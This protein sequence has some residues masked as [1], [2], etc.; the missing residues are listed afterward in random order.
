ML[1]D[2]LSVT[3]NSVAKS[4]PR[5]GLS[6]SR[7]RYMTVDKEFRVEITRAP[8]QRDGIVRVSIELSRQIPDPTP[9]NV[10][11]D[12]REVRNLFGLT[13]SFD[14]TRAETSVDVPLL[15]TA[16]LSFVDST[17]QGRLISGEY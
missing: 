12:Y 17:M 8:I 3:Y 10:F 6:A 5:I 1:S 11:D 13:Y 9:T 15:R 7:S 16:L 14:T 4:L 2:P